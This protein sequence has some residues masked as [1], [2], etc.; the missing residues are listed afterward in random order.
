MYYVPRGYIIMLKKGQK[1]KNAETQG[2]LQPVVPDSRTEN[3]SLS[4]PKVTNNERVKIEPLIQ[5]DFLFS[6]T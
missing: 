4:T 5:E 6:L 1:G 2:N 3:L